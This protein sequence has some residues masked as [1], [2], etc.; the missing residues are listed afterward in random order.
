[1]SERDDI[2]TL[3]EV[4]RQ[5]IE[6]VMKVCRGDR[7]QAATLLGIGQRTLFDRLKQYGYPPARRARKETHAHPVT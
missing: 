7:Q 2:K 6:I 5:H 3:A 4:E 1:M